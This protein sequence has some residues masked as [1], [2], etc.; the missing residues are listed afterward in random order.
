MAVSGDK[1]PSVEGEYYTETQRL[2]DL[3]RTDPHQDFTCSHGDGDGAV[4]IYEVPKGCV[5][6]PGRETQTLCAQHRVSD[7]SFEGI[8]L[9]VDLSIDGGWSRHFGEEPD[10]YIIRDTDTA[11]HMLIAF[12]DSPFEINP[13]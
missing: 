6:L 8:H 13:R 10:M 9:V 4:G 12:A 11:E 3:V 7:G 2:I 5:A 1:E